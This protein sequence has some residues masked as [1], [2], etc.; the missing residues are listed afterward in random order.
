M[1]N[2]LIKVKVDPKDLKAIPGILPNGKLL[3]GGPVE[4]KLGKKEIQRCMNFAD[5]YDLSSGEEVLID[6]KVFQELVEFVE[7]DVEVEEEVVEETPETPAPTPENTNPETP[8]QQDQV[9]PDDEAG[10]DDENP[11]E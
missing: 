2:N 5:V 11:E 4:L 8:E 1:K 6:E 9:T 7:D 3:Q 10:K